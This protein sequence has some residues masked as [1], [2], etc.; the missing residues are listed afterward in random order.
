MMDENDTLTLWQPRTCTVLTCQDAREIATNF[1]DFLI[2]LADWDA[3]RL[4]PT[5]STCST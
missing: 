2:T 3:R 1:A 4:R 5:C